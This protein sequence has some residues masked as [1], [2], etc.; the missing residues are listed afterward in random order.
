MYLDN[1]F[2]NENNICP[3][4]DYDGKEYLLDTKNIIYYESDC[5][6]NKGY[7]DSI[8]Y[9]F[10]YE[11]YDNIFSSKNAFKNLI[12]QLLQFMV[13]DENKKYKFSSKNVSNEGILKFRDY[14]IE[15]SLSLFKKAYI[16]SRK[17]N[18]KKIKPGY[19]L[20]VFT[21]KN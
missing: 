9:E 1:N 7:D 20:N 8:D 6:G 12:I 13:S 2:L 3:S 5:H 15:F 21:I 19:L 11:M 18:L 10:Y 17:C 4:Y 16:E 14:Y